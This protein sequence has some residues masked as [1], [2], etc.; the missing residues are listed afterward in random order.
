MLPDKLQNQIIDQN[1]RLIQHLNSGQHT[2]AEVRQL[3]GEIT[4]QTIDDSVEIGLPFYSDYGRN[5]K[6][7]REVFINSNAMMV[8][9]G[10][11][12]IADHALIGPGA[13]LISVN[14]YLDVD[15]RRGVT[16]KPVHI[17]KNAWIGARAVVLPGVSVGE[18]AVVA[19]GAVV[20]KNV[21]ANT[22]VAG[23]PAKVIKILENHK[24]EI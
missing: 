10:G 2:Q 23:V 22:V 15:K 19:A 16:L 12:T 14:H 17:G 3:V 8:D 13:Y 24:E 4:G 5:L 21:A 9:L 20:S 18:N 7:G 11:I 6:I 1:Q